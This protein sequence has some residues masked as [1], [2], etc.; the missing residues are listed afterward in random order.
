MFDFRPSGGIN[1]KGIFFNASC[2]NG[3]NYD[4]TKARNIRRQ[5]ELNV[6]LL[7]WVILKLMRVFFTDLF[8]FK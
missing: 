1:Y 4:A 5:C 2:I 7:E 8:D 6:D 3:V